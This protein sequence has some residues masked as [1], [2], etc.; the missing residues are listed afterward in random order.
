MNHSIDTK[1]YYQPHTVIYVDYRKE[2][3]YISMFEEKE[4][5]L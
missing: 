1:I 2:Y 4:S 3:Y 5:T